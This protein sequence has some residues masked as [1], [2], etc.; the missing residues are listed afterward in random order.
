MFDQLEMLGLKIIN[1]SPQGMILIELNKLSLSGI[2]S[3]LR[4]FYFWNTV[5]IDMEEN[6]YG[7]KEFGITINISVRNI[8]QLYNNENINNKCNKVTCKAVTMDL[9]SS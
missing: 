5:H 7:S 1:S 9:N 3:K 6:L 8:L 4:E 2:S